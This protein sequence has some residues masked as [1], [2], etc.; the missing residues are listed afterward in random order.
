MTR[1]ASKRLPTA[2]LLRFI[3]HP[4][5][6]VLLLVISGASFALQLIVSWKSGQAQV[7]QPSFLHFDVCNGFANQRIAIITAALLAKRSRRIL[8]V[9]N[10]GNAGEQLHNLRPRL[11]SK[12]SSVHFSAFY[13][14]AAFASLLE[15]HGVN[16]ID[17]S[18]LN[19]DIL[20]T[21]IAPSAVAKSPSDLGM[22]A[23]V[24]VGCP[25]FDAPAMLFVKYEDMFWSILRNGLIP[26]KALRVYLDQ[27]LRLHGPVFN[28][29]HLRIEDDWLNF[30]RHW[31]AIRDGVTRDNC[32][33]VQPEV[34]ISTLKALRVSPTKPLYIASHWM[35]VPPQT[36]RRMISAL[37]AAGYNPIRSECSSQRELCAAIDYYHAISADQF[38]GN[39]VSTFSALIIMERRKIGM[40]ASYYNGGTLPVAQWLPFYKL[41]WILVTG[42]A[43]SDA[44]DWIT[45]AKRSIDS[46]LVDGHV[47]PFVLV[48]AHEKSIDPNAFSHQLA[49]LGAWLTT[50][51]VPLLVKTCDETRAQ[52]KISSPRSWGGAIAAMALEQQWSNLVQ[53]TY[54]LISTDKMQFTA[55]LDLFEFGSKLPAETAVV[56]CGT[57]MNSN[58]A[59]LTN[60]AGIRQ[61]LG[62]DGRRLDQTQSAQSVCDHWSSRI[63]PK[64]L[65]DKT[66]NK[67]DVTR[68]VRFTA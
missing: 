5:L 35:H 37:H 58:C 61:L 21:R 8:V 56:A 13:D 63:K 26:S 51:G 24:H 50:R 12:F 33:V 38:I 14:E 6:T 49:D 19:T 43:L 57:R 16:A 64:H 46:G 10:L 54:A 4:L 31:I 20:P 65:S 22:T 40:Y 1:R 34:I 25:I 32:L 9:P 7:S 67:N 27:R 42:P 59:V 48:L 29:L 60:L 44:S 28:F 3:P 62:N 23:H 53:H 11:P 41:A 68:L 2:I 36:Q 45:R 18:R 52:R 55:R 15:A 66:T 17:R 39:S 47:L 30:C